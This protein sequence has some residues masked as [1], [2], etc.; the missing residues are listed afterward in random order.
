M[1][2]L[3][4]AVTWGSPAYAADTIGW[5]SGMKC[6]FPG[7]N[8]PFSIVKVAWAYHVTNGIYVY[9]PYAVHVLEADG[10]HHYTVRSA[11]MSLLINQ[12]GTGQY[13]TWS[14]TTTY[15]FGP[16]RLGN[17]TSY[18]ARG[19]VALQT[20]LTSPNGNTCRVQNSPS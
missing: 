10:A 18:A 17:I 15:T 8:S 19:Q 12:G 1:F 9:K 16:T 7:S 20:V 13:D 11:V 5:D 14:G 3:L 4:G 6:F 2:A